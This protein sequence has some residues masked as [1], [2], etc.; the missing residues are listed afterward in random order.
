MEGGAGEFEIEDAGDERTGPVGIVLGRVG[1]DEEI[2]RSR[3]GIEARGTEEGDGP[4]HVR[5]R[6]D[7]EE[8]I[9]SQDRSE[10]AGMVLR[11]AGFRF[12]DDAVGRHAEPLRDSA[13]RRGL[14]RM[15]RDDE[16]GR[17][18]RLPQI[19]ASG[20]TG[21]TMARKPGHDRLSFDVEVAS[22]EDHDRLGIP[23]GTTGFP[24]R[25]SR[26]GYCPS[27]RRVREWATG[28]ILAL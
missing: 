8:S 19:H 18:K 21:E 16:A 3:H 7:E 4:R 22:R 20:D 28:L 26:G 23:A 14:I 9:A 2:D 27:S 15:P 12:L 11:V 1:P 6:G 10:L 24:S 5:R 25:S 17:G 13:H